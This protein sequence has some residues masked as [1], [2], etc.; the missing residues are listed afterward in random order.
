MPK[1]DC[2]YTTAAAPLAAAEDT[3]LRCLCSEFYVLRAVAKYVPVDD[4]EVLR[5]RRTVAD[6]IMAIRPATDGARRA[7]ARVAI[8]ML[9]DGGHPFGGGDLGV[10]RMIEGDGDA[11][12]GIV[13]GI[14][15]MAPVWTA[16]LL[17]A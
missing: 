14:I 6:R 17:F 8:A 15:I 10:V 13:F 1:A 12:R 7:K 11:C 3:E 4:V 5:A 16:L 2:A 9:E